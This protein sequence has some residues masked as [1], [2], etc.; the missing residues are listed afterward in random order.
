MS[1]RV[2][3]RLIKPAG[4]RV[5]LE[6]F[7]G[8]ATC[9]DVAGARHHGRAYYGLIDQGVGPAAGIPEPREI[10]DAAWPTRCARCDAATTPDQIPWDDRLI[11][12]ARVWATPSGE[13]RPGD[14]YFDYCAA[15]RGH[16]CAHWDD[17]D[18]HHLVAVLPG[19]AG[20]PG[21]HWNVDGRAPNCDR[22]DR[23]HR[24]WI[25]QGEPGPGLHVDKGE[26]IMAA[27]QE[28]G[29]L[30]PGDV[31]R[32]PGTCQAGAGSIVAPDGWHGVLHD[33]ILIRIP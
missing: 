5:V 25:R 18:G 2:A 33:G 30:A 24:C 29:A 8:P 14:M 6:T 19:S 11:Y 13:L 20:G 28:L 10:P 17:C 22:G 32:Y 31:S 1:D 26:R 4:S 3:V 16:R 12:R 15:A 23:H 7:F 21:Y 9:G 27:A